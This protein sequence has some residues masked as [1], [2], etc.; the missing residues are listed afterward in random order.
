MQPG[1][2]HCIKNP[3]CASSDGRLI[4]G[5]TYPEHIDDPLYRGPVGMVAVYEGDP[6]PDEFYDHWLLI[7]AEINS[8]SNFVALLTFTIS[9]REKS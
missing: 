5:F 2:K 4:I 6:I 3:E 7:Y 8:N 1:L 9:W